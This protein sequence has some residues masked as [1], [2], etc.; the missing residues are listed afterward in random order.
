MFCPKDHHFVFVEVHTVWVACLVFFKP[1]ANPPPSPTLPSCPWLP[2]DSTAC[3]VARG[4]YPQMVC[5]AP[6]TTALSLWRSTPCARAT[7]RATD[8]RVRCPCRRRVVPVKDGGL[9]ALW[10][11]GLVFSILDE[12]CR[13]EE[14]SVPGG[15]ASFHPPSPPLPP[16]PHAPGCLKTAQPV[17]SLGVGIPQ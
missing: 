7:P 2:Q 17:L 8:V 6:R 11:A 10:V 1:D 12:S 13:A 4:W 14:D 16:S 3:L 9:A 15:D 5:F